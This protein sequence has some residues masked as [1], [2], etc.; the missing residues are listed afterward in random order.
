MPA[1]S[2]GVRSC[3]VVIRQFW[4]CVSLSLENRC[5]TELVSEMIK[6]FEKK[7]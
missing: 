6:N 2:C 1:R 7:K 3:H 4:K 5:R